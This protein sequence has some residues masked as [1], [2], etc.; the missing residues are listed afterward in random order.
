MLWIYWHV[1]SHIEGH[2]S[3]VHNRGRKKKQSKQQLR[4][5][6][7]TDYRVLLSLLW[8]QNSSKSVRALLTIVNTH[9]YTQKHTHTLPKE[10]TENGPLW[11]NGLELPSS[12][13]L[14]FT[15]KKDS[16]R[17]RVEVEGGPCNL[18]WCKMQTGRFLKIVP[19]HQ[20]AAW[21]W[22]M[23][24]TNAY[25]DL[26]SMWHSQGCLQTFLMSKTENDQGSIRICF[27]SYS[28]KR[29]WQQT[30]FL[31]SGRS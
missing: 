1:H 20:E 12:A 11:V 16:N 7:L 5:V 23:Y 6:K 10:E 26:T 22:H 13:V 18:S 29:V 24:P 17:G 14:K 3:A 25:C 4:R 27:V 19:L 8:R 31:L 30:A 15:L 2:R 21:R 28:K 9:I